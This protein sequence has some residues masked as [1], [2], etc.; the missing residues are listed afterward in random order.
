MHVLSLYFELICVHNAEE[1]LCN[2]YNIILHAG[3][4]A[5]SSCMGLY[6]SAYSICVP[7]PLHYPARPSGKTGIVVAVIACIVVGIG[8]LVVVVIVSWCIVW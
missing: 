2:T 6:T 8:I 1:I 4:N 7:Y 5:V 3:S